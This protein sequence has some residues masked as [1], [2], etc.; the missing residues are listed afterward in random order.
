[1]NILERLSAKHNYLVTLNTPINEAHVIKHVD[2]RHP[3]YDNKM[4][5]AQKRWHEISA[6]QHTHFCGA[7]WF[8]GFHEDGVKKWLAGMPK[9]GGGYRYFGHYQYHSC[10]NRCTNQ[11]AV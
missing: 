8:N 3:V 11:T 5:N 4:T 10:H 2:Y 1:M 9:F 6:K 7:Y